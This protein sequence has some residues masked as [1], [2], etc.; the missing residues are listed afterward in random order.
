MSIRIKIDEKSLFYGLYNDYVKGQTATV[1]TP[2]N[3]S[4]NQYKWHRDIISLYDTG[5]D[6]GNIPN[7]LLNICQKK[8]TS[9]AKSKI[10]YFY[11]FK[12]LYLDGK[13]LNVNSSF[14]VYIKEEIDE[15]ITH[16]N[17]TKG[18]NTHFGRQKLHYPIGLRYRENGINVDN[19]R[20]LD[21]ILV[22]NGQFAFVVRGFEIDVRDKSLNFITS[23]IGLKGT[24][25]S[26]VFRIK[27]GV[28]KKLLVNEI[29]LDAQDISQDSYVMI[30]KINPEKF[31]DTKFDELSKPEP[32]MVGLV[33]NMLVLISKN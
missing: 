33:K 10:K 3:Q 26:N 25:L 32:R 13:S 7:D 8:T 22:Q 2:I 17:G 29:D 31:K 20:V 23:M 19:R 14:G 27:K 1:S 11:E 12:K 18:I 28:G 5:I 4:K 30:S 6:I 21:T 15:Y 24:F 9:K 16:R